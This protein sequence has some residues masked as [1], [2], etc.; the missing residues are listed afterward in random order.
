MGS[1]IFSGLGD[2]VPGGGSGNLGTKVKSRIFH[3]HVIDVVMN[4]KSEYYDGPQDIGKVRFRDLANTTIFTQKVEK[5]ITTFAYPLDR[6]ITKI[7]L[8]GEQVIIFR[9][10]GDVKGETDEVTQEAFF[11]S[12][13]V[14]NT[15]N[16]T[17]NSEPFLQNDALSVDRPAPP[18]SV[19]LK[20]FTDK[21]QDEKSFKE[22]GDTIKVYKQ[23][24]PFEGDFILQGRFGQCIR[25]GSS[26]EETTIVPERPWKD[27]KSGDPVMVLRVDKDYVTDAKDMYVVENVDED[28]ASIYMISNQN[29]SMALNCTKLMKTWRE[30]F[31]VNDSGDNGAGDKFKTIPS[32]TSELYKPVKFVQF[33]NDP[34]KSI[35]DV[36][37]NI[38]G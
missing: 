19:A 10:V 13:A 5:E 1:G 3:A 20:R 22:G 11:Y 29:L 4:D 16:I 25:L 28:D 6:S 23:L 27:G 8:P 7:P 37:A 34:I 30:T 36:S 38:T 15:H 32:S 17:Y 35:D 9:A 14:S 2:F 12:F 18:D 31:T 21:L 24:Q 33:E 26:T